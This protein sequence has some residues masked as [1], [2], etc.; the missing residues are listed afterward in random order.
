MGREVWVEAE[1]RVGEGTRDDWESDERR[2]VG[3]GLVSFTWNLAPGSTVA[4][5]ISPRLTRRP[6]LTTQERI[7]REIVFLVHQNQRQILSTS[8]LSLLL[9]CSNLLVC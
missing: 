6:R 9:F 3:N 2:W 7:R 8:C 5:V 1:M 4:L